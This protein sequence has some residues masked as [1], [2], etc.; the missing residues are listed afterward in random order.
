[1]AFYG[2]PLARVLDRISRVGAVSVH[3]YQN[4]GEW[5]LLEPE[6]FEDPVYFAIL[7]GQWKSIVGPNA[8]SFALIYCQGGL[9]P[10]VWLHYLKTPR[11]CAEYLP[12]CYQIPVW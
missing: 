1:M 7:H 9:E 6:L 12:G 11:H 5:F 3:D 4:S 10:G 2:Q 8:S